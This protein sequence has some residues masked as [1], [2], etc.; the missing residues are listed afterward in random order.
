M[1]C[2]TK[3][4]QDLTELNHYEEIKKLSEISNKIL[5][6]GVEHVYEEKKLEA[7]FGSSNFEFLPEKDYHFKRLNFLIMLQKEKDWF[8]FIYLMKNLKY[9]V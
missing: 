9:L 6:N 5:K 4:T 8:L 3:I 7:T 2:F 1:S